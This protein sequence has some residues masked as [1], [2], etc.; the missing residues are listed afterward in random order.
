MDNITLSKST[1]NR[2][3]DTA[4]WARFI[5][6]LGFILIGFLIVVG[7]FIGPVLSVLNENMDVESS[8]TALSSGV[9]AGIYIAMAVIYFFPIFYLFQFSQGFITAYKAENEEK[10][11]TSF[12]YLKKHY[13]FIGILTIIMIAIYFLIFVVGMLGLMLR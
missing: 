11:N 1:L 3:Y 12:L 10:V 2:L 13:K 6:I 5:A 8:R 4:K 9:I 7:I